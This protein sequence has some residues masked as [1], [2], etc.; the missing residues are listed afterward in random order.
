MHDSNIVHRDIKL[1]NILYDRSKKEIKIIDFGLAAIL[2]PNRL[3]NDHCGTI[4]YTA[5]EIL[6]KKSYN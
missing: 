1:D 6:Y 5:P 4:G 3:L 2:K